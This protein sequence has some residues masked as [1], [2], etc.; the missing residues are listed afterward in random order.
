MNSAIMLFDVMYAWTLHEHTIKHC[1]ACIVWNVIVFRCNNCHFP[2]HLLSH[3][4]RSSRLLPLVRTMQNYVMHRCNVAIQPC[5]CSEFG[6]VHLCGKPGPYCIKENKKSLLRAVT[7]Q[8][9]KLLVHDCNFCFK[10]IG[11]CNCTLLLE[12]A[13]LVAWAK[14][15]SGCFCKMWGCAI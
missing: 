7:G 15:A 4:R 14:Y 12:S 1:V 2:H 5:C 9:M 6:G 3:A 11:G 10:K 8:A 13:W